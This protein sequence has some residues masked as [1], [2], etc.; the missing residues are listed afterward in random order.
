MAADRAEKAGGG[1][2]ELIVKD[3]KSWGG[4]Q[5]VG[6]FR[7]FT[8]IVGCNGSGKSNL[9]DAIRLV[10][11]ATRYDAHRSD[12]ADSFVLGVKTMQLR[13]SQVKD[14]IHR[15]VRLDLA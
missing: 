6:P 2:R 12:N 11:A 1:I 9:M 13:G 7:T 3:F 15:A 5:V 14:L 4:E 10:P 8:C